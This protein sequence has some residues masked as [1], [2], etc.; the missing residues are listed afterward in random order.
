MNSQQRFWAILSNDYMQLSNIWYQKLSSHP[1]R[2]HEDYWSTVNEFFNE[3]VNWPVPLQVKAV[4][5]AL[6]VYKFPFDP[7]RIKAFDC[8]HERCNGYII[9]NLRNLESW[10]VDNRLN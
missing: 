10:K 3:I 4:K 8:F 1:D 2:D 5:T 6:S 7:D 9:S